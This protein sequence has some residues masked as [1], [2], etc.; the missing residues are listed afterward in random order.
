MMILL[1]LLNYDGAIVKVTY[2]WILVMSIIMYCCLGKRV[3]VNII[4]PMLVSVFFCLINLLFIGNATYLSII[5]LFSGFFIALMILD[6]AT[7]SH[8]FLIGFL[9][10]SIY[11]VIMMMFKGIRMMDNGLTPSVF[12][13]GFSNNYVSVYLIAISCLFYV[14]RELEN[15]PII[16]WPSLVTAVLSVLAGGRMGAASAVL[17][18]GLLF[19]IKT[20]DS[21]SARIWFG[22]I[23]IIIIILTSYTITNYSS[24]LRIFNRTNAL[25][26]IRFKFIRDYIGLLQNPFFL[27]FG[28][29]VKSLDYLKQW[30]YNLHNS[31]LMVHS[32][33]GIIVFLG[34]IGMIL[35]SIIYAIKE[36]R[37][38]FIACLVTFLIR[39]LTDSIIGCNRLTPAFLIFLL[40]PYANRYCIRAEENS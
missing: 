40:Y 13:G 28:G 18:F 38:V 21:K 5:M 37:L 32:K 10:F 26:D 27:F 24:Y 2:Y 35:Y 3:S 7:T 16:M 31:Y 1:A 22:P 12:M 9:F 33:L 17:L 6:D 8:V 34:M 23:V 36:K 15:K 39:C 11:V 14:K 29:S 4:I 19:M 20:L 25:S 30:D